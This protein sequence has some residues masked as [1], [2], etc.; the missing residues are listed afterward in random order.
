[1]RWMRL[2]ALSLVLALGLA[3]WGC[4]SKP[5]PP[6]IVQLTAKAGTSV[7]PDADSRASPVIL[8][9]YQLTATD[10]FEKADFFQLYDKDAATLGSDLVGRD[11]LALA[12]GDTKTISIEFKPAAKFIGVIA[13]FRSLDRATW[14]ADAPVPANKTTKLAVTVDGLVVKLGPGS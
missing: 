12:P 14:R 13:A 2:S 11:Q 8:R 6:A 3:L 7:N 4:G 1:M 10:T 5:P 9:I